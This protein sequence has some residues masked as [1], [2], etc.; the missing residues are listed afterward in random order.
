[1]FSSSPLMSTLGREWAETPIHEQKLLEATFSA[2]LLA[3]IGEHPD[4][5]DIVSELTEASY[6]GQTDG[7][8]NVHRIMRRFSR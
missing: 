2:Q 1:M 5:E 7:K 6:A 4:A 3:C 8:R